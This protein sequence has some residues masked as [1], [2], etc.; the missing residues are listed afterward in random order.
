MKSLAILSLFIS[1]VV[2][3]M[4]ASIYFYY[5]TPLSEFSYDTTAFVTHDVAGFDVNTTV[6]TFGSIVPGGTSTRSL[7]VNN[8]YPFP[9][10][11]EPEAD[12][13]I[14][15]ILHFEPL[16]IEPYQSSQFY[17]TVYADSIDS[18]GNYTG[19]IMI[20]LLRAF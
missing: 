19:N 10:K 14:E 18:I 9:I 2:L 16:V 3:T 8:S 12:G 4:S 1:L 20:R 17:F 7:M 13:S 15:K 6:I 11:V 5:I